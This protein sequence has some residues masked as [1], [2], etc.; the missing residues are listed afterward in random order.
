MSA[1]MLT[2][3]VLFTFIVRDYER[4]TQQGHWSIT[5]QNKL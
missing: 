4:Q 3:V 2:L 1:I 5:M